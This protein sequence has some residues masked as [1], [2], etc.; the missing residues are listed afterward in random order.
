MIVFRLGK[1]LDRRR[2]CTRILER[3]KRKSRRNILRL[4]VTKVIN[5]KKVKSSDCN[6]RASPGGAVATFNQQNRRRRRRYVCLFGFFFYIHTH[7]IN[8]VAE[9]K[10]PYLHIDDDRTRSSTLKPRL[11]ELSV[12]RTVTTTNTTHTTVKSK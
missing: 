10:L 12:P 1:V 11:V 4:F 2:A 6:G 3:S 5:K 8:R 7:I 9:I